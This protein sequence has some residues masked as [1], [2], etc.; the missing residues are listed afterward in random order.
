MRR[1]VRRS[2][3]RPANPPRGGHSRSGMVSPACQA[4]GV[5]A[6]LRT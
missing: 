3:L 1:S 6:L 2:R 4:D 5:P